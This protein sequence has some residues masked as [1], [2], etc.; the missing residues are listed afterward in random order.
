MNRFSTLV[1]ALVILFVGS[2][3]GGLLTAMASYGMCQTGCNALWV[4]CIAA[5]GGVAGVSTGG[6]A[7]PAVI[8]ACNVAQGVCMAACAAAILA[9]P[10]P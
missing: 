3:D 10:T 7:V 8:I 1:V 2:S 6:A 4:A 5:A 9:V